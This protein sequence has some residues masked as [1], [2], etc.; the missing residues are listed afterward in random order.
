MAIALAATLSSC[1][2]VE[3]IFD[4]SNDKEDEKF[5]SDE[6]NVVQRNVVTVELSRRGVETVTLPEEGNLLILPDNDKGTASLLFSSFTIIDPEKKPVD[7]SW[8]QGI[9]WIKK[10]LKV[11]LVIDDVPLKVS[12]EGVYKFSK[13]TVNG[14]LTYGDQSGDLTNLSNQR[15]DCKISISGEMTQ[16]GSNGA[17]RYNVPMIGNLNIK[18]IT[19]DNERLLLGYTKL[20]PEATDR[21]YLDIF[22]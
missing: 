15:K 12:D 13:K 2:L 9:T 4:W 5:T 17:V 10:A 16:E 14:V 1:N 7:W 3:D 20:N 8:E 22:R 21:G 19:P 18:I 6:W 11:I